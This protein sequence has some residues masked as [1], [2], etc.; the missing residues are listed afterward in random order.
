MMVMDRFEP[1]GVVVFPEELFVDE[2]WGL[3]LS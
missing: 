1:A 3:D 2:W